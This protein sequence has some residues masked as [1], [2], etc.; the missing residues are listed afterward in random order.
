MLAQ[1]RG[2]CEILADRQHIHRQQAVDCGQ[3][4]VQVEGCQQDLGAPI[5]VTHV[6]AAADR[7]R[8]RIWSALDGC[9]LQVLIS[10]SIAQQIWQGAIEEVDPHSFIMQVLHAEPE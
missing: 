1:A 4:A 3:Q 10:S 5:R 7:H 6:E 8:L 9:E 2:C